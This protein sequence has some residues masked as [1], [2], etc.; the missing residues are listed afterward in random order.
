MNF[1]AEDSSY[2]LKKLLGIAELIQ[3][4]LKVL[5]INL[6]AEPSSVVD[7]YTYYARKL[8]DVFARN[9]GELSVFFIK[10]EDKHDLVNR[11]FKRDKK[12]Y[13]QQ[14]E[15]KLSLS[16]SEGTLL[17]AWGSANKGKL[18]LY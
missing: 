4:N 6:P 16:L 10:L 9:G 7:T 3:E 18:G 17:Y 8:C 13:T 1:L 14:S 12:H 11:I 5:V 2:L 15:V